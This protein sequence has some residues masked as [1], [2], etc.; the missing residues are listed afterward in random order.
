MTSS[1]LSVAQAANDA[2][3]GIQEDGL[4]GRS[5]KELLELKDLLFKRLMEGVS[6]IPEQRFRSAIDYINDK[7]K[8]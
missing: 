6:A 7:L 5:K 1:K 8:I 4:D 3:V 2:L